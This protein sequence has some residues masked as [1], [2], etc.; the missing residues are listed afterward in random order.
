V[1]D[2]VAHDADELIGD[3]TTAALIIDERGF[4]KQARVC[5]GESS[6]PWTN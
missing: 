2:H 3:G 1:L 6:I 5:G 4:A